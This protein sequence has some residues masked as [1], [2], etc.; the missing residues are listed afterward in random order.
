MP[1]QQEKQPTMKKYLNRMK[2]GEEGVIVELQ[3]GHVF[4]QRLEAMGI[5]PGKHIKLISKQPLRGP[6][7]IQAGHSRIAL[8][9]GMA[10]KIVVE[11]SE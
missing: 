3:G 1:I 5:H 10:Q 7:A 2:A 8:G 11:C 4:F 6:V 9:H